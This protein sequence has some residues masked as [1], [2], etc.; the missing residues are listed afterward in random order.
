MSRTSLG[1]SNLTSREYAKCAGRGFSVAAATLSPGISSQ[2]LRRG[3]LLV[4]VSLLS[5][6]LLAAAAAPPALADTLPPRT[7]LQVSLWR[8]GHP[9]ERE[10]LTEL[11]FSFQRANPD[12]LVALEWQDAELA[13]E[14]LRRW[15]GGFRQHAPDVTVV[16]ELAAYR[17]REEFIELSAGLRQRLR[18]DFEPSVLRRARGAPHGV[19]WAVATPA[20]Y[21]RA[22]LLEE[23]GLAV[24]STLEELLECA[25]ELADPPHRYGLGL[26]GPGGGGET[27]LHALA[28]AY[29]PLRET[30]RRHEDGEQSDVTEEPMEEAVE[31]LEQALDLLVQM[32][33]AGALQPEVLTWSEAE[34]VELF[35]AGRLAMMIA[36]PEAARALRVTGQAQQP[37]EWAT[38]AMPTQPEGIGQVQVHWLVIFRSSNRQEIAMRFLSYMAEQESQRALA[39]MPSVPATRLLAGELAGTQPW[40]GHVPALEGGEG[41][42]ISTWERFRRELAD[43]FAWAMSGRLSPNEALEHARR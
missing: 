15:C 1:A 29:G 8:T 23:A 2:G 3:G 38:A 33:A 41:V 5:V 31:P 40:S 20:L 24:P 22:D 12:V 19:P 9:G 37:V 34:L 25:T 21:Y 16:S 26:P 13:D 36:Q 11:V 30:E 32:Q 6:L 39:M 17:Y 4:T 28:Q 14:L 10:L 18:S 7:N 35:A 27:L 43:A 42:P